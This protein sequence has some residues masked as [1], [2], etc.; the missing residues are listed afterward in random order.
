MNKAS[1]TKKLVYAAVLS[2]MV[3]VATMV[4]KIPLPAHGYFNLGDGAVLLS[5]ALLGPLWGPMSAGVGSALSDLLSG[6][7]LYAPVTFVIKALMAALFS[8]LETAL[9]K[10][11]LMARIVGGAAAELVMILGYLLFESVL[12]RFE[13][14]LAGVGANAVQAL[15]G[16]AFGVLLTTVFEKNNIASLPH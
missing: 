7:A 8:L 4:L 10:R 9:A 13:A 5:G 6:Y 11:P 15:I 3:C 1:T 16:L 12:Y 14:A 2:A